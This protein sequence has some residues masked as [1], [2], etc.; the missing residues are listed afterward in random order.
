M[1]CRGLTLEV[2]VSLFPLRSLCFVLCRCADTESDV[3]DVVYE[4]YKA[5]L[6]GK[7]FAPEQLQQVV[8]LTFVFFSPS[9][10][11]LRSQS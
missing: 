7:E 11:F 1:G 4:G 3:Q 2:Y 10:P 5:S 8:G 9:P 6:K